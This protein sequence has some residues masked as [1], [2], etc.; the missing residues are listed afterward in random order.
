MENF[1]DED[2]VKLYI[3]TR[4]NSY[5]NALYERYCPKVRR[6]C[7]LFIR[8]EVQAEDL[9]QDIFIKLLNKI[10]SYKQE[11]RFS[12]WLYSVI[13][14]HCTD[15]IRTPHTKQGLA[16]DECYDITALFTSDPDQLT[17]NQFA[18]ITEWQMKLAMTRLEPEEQGL[19]RMKYMD[20][21]SVREIADQFSLTQSA[22]KM[23]LKRSRDR[24][25]QFYGEVC[26]DDSLPYELMYS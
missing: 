4:K 23:R 16:L 10:N 15:Q 6:R 24:L 13:R 17:E 20:E 8:D 11:S 12:T 19:L 14:N 5:F 26:I 1:T 2:L 7:L 22:V 25:R 18:E 9:T 3:K 21:V